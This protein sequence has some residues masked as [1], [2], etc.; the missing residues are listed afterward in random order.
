[1]Q[2]K[3]GALVWPASLHVLVDRHPSMHACT[4]PPTYRHHPTTHAGEVRVGASYIRARWRACL[5]RL[6]AH[7]RRAQA[8]LTLYMVDRYT[9]QAAGRA[10]REG[11]A[12]RIR[13]GGALPA[14]QAVDQVDHDARQIGRHEQPVEFHPGRVLG[15][16]RRCGRQ[17]CCRHDVQERNS[18]HPRLHRSRAHGVDLGGNSTSTACT[19]A[20]QLCV[21]VC[22]HC[23][24]DTAASG[25]HLTR[26][27]GGITALKL[28]ILQH[29]GFAP[30]PTRWQR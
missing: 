8:R 24:W 4:C 9:A 15:K 29:C 26:A 7:S 13:C 22:A 6:H 5:T 25:V 12:W 20:G 18:L 2:T 30:C 11:G 28:S 27:S 17:G 14:Q 19:Q 21:H 3:E 23:P 16:P 1:M 10:H